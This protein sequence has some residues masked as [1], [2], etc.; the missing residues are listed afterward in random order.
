MKPLL[1]YPHQGLGDHFIINGLVRTLVER[2]PSVVLICR[3]NNLGT[4]R[5]M[6]SDDS[7]IQVVP[8]LDEPS[9]NSRDIDVLRLGY[10]SGDPSFNAV[11]YDQ[12]FYKQAGVPFENRWSKFR[13]PSAMFGASSHGMNVVHDDERFSIASNVPKPFVKIMP[14]TDNLF[15]WMRLIIG[16]GEIHCI[17]SSVF[18]LV[19]S[20]GISVPKLVLHAYVRQD[21][22]YPSM[23][24]Q[25]KIISTFHDL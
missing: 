21:V 24:S 18:L 25:W 23:R 2:H 13:Y 17:P 4:V 9:W 14:Q 7:R 22:T 12:K 6:Y 15:D 16:A 3:E 5:F 10:C 20:I 19:D 8:E 1:I 11:D